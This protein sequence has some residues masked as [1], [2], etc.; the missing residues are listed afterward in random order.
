MWN[1]SVHSKGL[2][3]LKGRDKNISKLSVIWKNR[4]YGKQ[5]SLTQIQEALKIKIRLA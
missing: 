4:M 3:E 5:S 1:Y 2:P